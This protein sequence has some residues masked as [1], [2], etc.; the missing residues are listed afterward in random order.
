LLEIKRKKIDVLNGHYHY[1]FDYKLGKKWIP[2]NNQKF[3]LTPA[4]KRLCKEA[5]EIAILEIQ[6]EFENEC[7]TEM[8]YYTFKQFLDNVFMIDKTKNRQYSTTIGYNT[9]IHLCE[10][11]NDIKLT[12][13]RLK[14][15]Q[16]IFDD[17]KER[18]CKKNTI[19]TY[20]RNLNTIFT[21]AMNNEIIS[22]MP[23][24][25]LELCK[26]E[27]SKPKRA[28]T[29]K[30]Y[31]HVLS[32]F[33]G[34]YNKYYL[35]ILIAATTGM[36]AAEIVGLTWDDINFK[37]SMIDVN[38]QWKIVTD[39]CGYEFAKT[40]STNGNRDIPI[41]PD[42]LKILKEYK[43]KAKGIRILEEFSSSQSVRIMVGRYFKKEKFGI[44]LHE[45]RHTYVNII[46]NLGLD[47]R[48]VAKILGHSPEVNLKVYTHFNDDMMNTAKA[49][50]T[51]FPKS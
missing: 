43:L 37:T 11:L 34:R 41:P 4:G 31:N 16:P 19:I 2:K 40:K 15:I 30:E 42:T 33:E 47:Y 12:D 20:A 21:S 10:G 26:D 46:Q 48:I 39:K 13:I 25:H 36:R 14:D 45:M 28:L 9:I 7:D 22:K 3:E 5:M 17:M 6:K 27:I 38:K 32:V 44:T 8:R 18:K 35:F 50:I 51:N 24:K 1:R 49:A 29:I 23:T